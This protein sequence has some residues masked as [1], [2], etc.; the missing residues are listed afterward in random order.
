MTSR[1]ELLCSPSDSKVD[2]APQERHGESLEVIRKKILLRLLARREADRLG[3]VACA[4]ELQD[5]LDSFRL[6]YGLLTTDEM[7]RWL[8]SEGLKPETI[9]RIMYD[10]VLLRKIEQL[11]DCDIA[12]EIQDH[13]R[14]SSVRH[15]LTKDSSGIESVGSLANWLQVNVALARTDGNITPNARMLFEQLSFAIADWR[16]EKNLEIFFFMRKPP[17][18]RL[19]LFGRNPEENLLPKLEQILSTLKHGGFIKSFFRSIYEP[20]T[21]LFG[22]VLAMNVVHEHF[23]ADSMAWIGFDRLVASGRQTIQSETLVLAVLNDLFVRTIPCPWE[24]W[25][26]WCN[27]ARLGPPTNEMHSSSIELVFID[28]LLPKV[29]KNEKRILQD[30]ARSNQHLAEGLR[31]LNE[32]KLLCGLRSI[33]PFIAIFLLNRHGLGHRH[34][35]LANGMSQTWNPKRNL[36]GFEVAHPSKVSTIR[37]DYE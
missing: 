13:I 15:R 24:V 28:D 7:T 6:K 8:E 16:R 37:S 3:I 10:L 36:R 26:V 31:Q 29:S 2:D 25:D 1:A 27:V 22:G 30:Y 21:S 11:N 4:Q 5:A 23:D 17:D 32:G 35:I 18:L 14:L 9:R 19:R 12:R 33:L 20:E 34:A